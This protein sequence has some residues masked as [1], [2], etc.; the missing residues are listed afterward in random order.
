MVDLQLTN[1]EWYFLHVQIE[2]LIKEN[3]HNYIP[4]SILEKLAVN[5]PKLE[6]VKYVFKQEY[7]CE[8]IG[9]DNR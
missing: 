3:P 9:T 4:K 7:N 2:K 6:D 8:W 1:N 5:C